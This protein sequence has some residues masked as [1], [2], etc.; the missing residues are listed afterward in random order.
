MDNDTIRLFN[1]LLADT[2]DRSLFDNEVEPIILK[3]GSYVIVSFFLKEVHNLLEI[4]LRYHS[5]PTPQNK[6]SMLLAAREVASLGKNLSTSL[7]PSYGPV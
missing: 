5:Y 7:S 4:M 2:P 1:Q 6:L 3:P